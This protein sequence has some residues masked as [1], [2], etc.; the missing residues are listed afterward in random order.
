MRSQ[1]AFVFDPLVES[2]PLITA[3]NVVGSGQMI[4]HKKKPPI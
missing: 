4:H 3:K 1:A 2:L